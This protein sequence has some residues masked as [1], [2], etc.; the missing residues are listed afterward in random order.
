M[1][2]MRKNMLAKKT[3]KSKILEKYV[4]ILNEFLIFYGQSSLINE[5]PN[6]L[7]I[8]INTIHRVFEYV[9]ILAAS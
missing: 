7:C 8:G 3:F 1:Y 4:D 9:F 5:T 6:I 2:I